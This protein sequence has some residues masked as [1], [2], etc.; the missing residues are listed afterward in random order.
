MEIQASGGPLPAVTG[1]PQKNPPAA[2]PAAATQPTA[3]PVQID[4]AAA[5][6]QPAPIPTLAQL[7]QA[8]KNINKTL[9]VQAQDV[10][11]SIDSDS[12]RT[13]VKVVDRKTKE[14]LRQ[15]PTEETLQIAKALDRVSGLLI[16]QKA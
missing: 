8:V 10:E 12:N 7:D 4:S 11:F 3:P 15:I 1:L 6:R 16:R 5:V 14:V 2:D 9:Q 13:I